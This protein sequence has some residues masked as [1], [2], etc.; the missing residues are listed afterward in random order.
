MRIDGRLTALNI[1]AIT[2]ELINIDFT[3]FFCFIKREKWM[4]R[5]FLVSD[6]LSKVAK[7]AIEILGLP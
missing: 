7:I 5:V 6:P 2:I 4:L 3:D 1:Y